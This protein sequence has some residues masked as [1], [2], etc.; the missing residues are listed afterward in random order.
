MRESSDG[1]EPGPTFDSDSGNNPILTSITRKAMKEMVRGRGRCSRKIILSDEEDEVDQRGTTAVITSRADLQCRTET[2]TTVAVD[3]EKH[4][5]TPM[6]TSNE[7]RAALEAYPSPPPTKKRIRISLSPGGNTNLEVVSI[8][9]KPSEMKRDNKPRPIVISKR[10]HMNNADPVQHE[11]PT[12]QELW[13]EKRFDLSSPRLVRPLPLR[14]KLV[15]EKSLLPGGTY[16]RTY[17]PETP[18]DS[19]K[20]ELVVHPRHPN[21]RWGGV[22]ARRKLAEEVAKYERIKKFWLFN[23]GYAYCPS[24]DCKHEFVAMEF[25]EEMQSPWVVAWLAKLISHK[26]VYLILEHLEWGMMKE[27]G[28]ME[29]SSCNCSRHVYTKANTAT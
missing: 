2:V 25:A 1:I 7:K 29:K 22:W 11:T 19:I 8:E 27:M 5:P 17:I 15:E 26:D 13:E 20:K 12:P 28:D 14:Y 4:T 23:Y 6:M 24:W 16:D 10:N 3:L 21:I 9:H 18:A